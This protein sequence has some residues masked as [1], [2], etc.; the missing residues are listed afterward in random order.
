MASNIAAGEA[1]VLR[2][3]SS[4]NWNSD[5]NI[6]S[7]AQGSVPKREGQLRGL[8]RRFIERTGL[9][10]LVTL[11]GLLLLIPLA[12]LLYYF[13]SELRSSSESTA[14][15]KLGLEYIKP[16][17]QLKQA[18]QQHRDASQVVLSGDG[19]QKDRLVSQAAQAEQAVA[20]VDAVDSKLGA[21]LGVS[22]KWSETKQLWTAVSSASTQ[23]NPQ[24]SFD[25]HG[26]VLTT[27]LGLITDV[28]DNSNLT[29]DPEVD[30]YY[31][32]DAVTTKIPNISEQLAQIRTRLSGAS[33]AKK[34][35]NNEE[36]T[37]VVFLLNN[38]D[39]LEEGLLRSLAR[40]Y[41]AN[42]ALKDTLDSRAKVAIEGGFRGLLAA[43]RERFNK[44]EDV[45]RVDWADW[46][47]AIS[48]IVNDHHALAGALNESLSG[49]LDAR[50]NKLNSRLTRVLALAFALTL[51]G[52][53]VLFLAVRA[54]L[55]NS[56][57]IAEE[58]RRSGSENQKNQAAILKLLD[59]MEGLADGDLRVQASVTEDITGAI[60]D[61]VNY[62][63]GELRS[64]AVSADE[65]ATQVAEQAQRAQDM[66]TKLYDASQV[67]F[68]DIEANN[69]QMS[70][71]L[72]S[73]QAVSA[74]AAESS[75]VAQRSLL[76]AE[77]GHGAVQDSIKG[78]NEIRDQI[79][80]TSKRMKRLGEGSQQI[81]EI[82]E[83]IADITAQTNVLALNAAIQAASAGEA[84]RG[85]TIVAEEVQRLAER[86]AEATKQIAGIVRVIQSDTQDA[87]AAMEKSTQGVVEETKIADA[88]GRALT[89]IGQV[90]KQLAELIQSIS[91]AAA[92]QVS[93]T[94]K[95]A[96]NMD[97]VLSITRQ[98][99]TGTQQ[100]ATFLRHLT[101][102]AN[103]LKSSIARFK[104]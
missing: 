42:P 7:D 28:A 69:S 23:M 91:T 31:L 56:R 66:S 47:D 75:R 48:V 78:M 84:G 3:L 83:L 63:V 73:I 92:T 10:Q 53:T 29:L 71:V 58:A 90:S 19:G 59:E 24:Q 45:S 46:S 5:G 35:L 77:K 26:K 36:L 8:V 65:A 101:E 57:R 9:P 32:M 18:L 87:V 85:F 6:A 27:L 93:S 86:S 94:E 95:V 51:L 41:A 102:V 25:A 11:A 100:T 12:L 4:A 60:A 74:T 64:L 43:A 15:E 52:L 54:A 104:L 99:T 20:A 13:V 68:R 82:V 72:H 76:A 2:G 21:T 49:T 16:L 22:R 40:V 38:V 17:Y 33:A 80:E 81:G 55:A 103:A 79:Q 62:A 89:E 70:G 37:N 39:H 1:G 30:S 50:L 67:Q 34:G 97:R 98:T 88:A 44:A 96:Q 14:K 61:S